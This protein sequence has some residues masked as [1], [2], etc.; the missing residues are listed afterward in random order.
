VS[1]SKSKCLDPEV[2]ITRNVVVSTED[3]RGPW[4]KYIIGCLCYSYPLD[5]TIETK[6]EKLSHNKI[7]NK[8]NDRKW[9]KQS[10]PIASFKVGF[11]EDLLQGFKS[12]ACATIR[13]SNPVFMA[14]VR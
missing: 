10:L 8:V 5:S 14:S 3:E 6:N 7:F 11:T 13:S 1:L 9:L 12:N 4:R 2:A